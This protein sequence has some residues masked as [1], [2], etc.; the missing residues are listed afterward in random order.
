M[1]LKNLVFFLLVT[2]LIAA[3]EDDNQFEP[4]DYEAVAIVDDEL[5]QEYLE[6]HYYN[7]V[8]DSIK[9]VTDGERPF[10]E[11]VQVMEVEEND[12]N[13]KL[14]YIVREQGVGY[15]PSE[16]DDVLTTYRGELLTGTVFDK[17]ESIQVGN[18][19]FNLTGVIRGWAY[20]FT[21]FRGGTNIS[22]PDMP[23]EFEDYS[24]GFLFIPSGLAYA[25]AAQGQIPPSSPLVFTVALHHAAA[26]DHDDD[27][28]V[29]NAEDVD[30]DGD[31]SNDDTDEDGFANFFDPDDDGDGT[32]TKNED[33]NGDGDPTN[34]DTD[35]DGTPDYLDADS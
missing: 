25:G 33:A 23:I 7:E 11:D 6:T 1:K 24:T 20:G 15:Q 5:L 12:V 18:P 34:D 31:P 30:G 26:A 3:C 22:Q 13:Y 2:L 32:L 14:Y 21:H 27:G 16:Y 29:T 4:Y 28:V 17:R 10:S 35:G 8:L 9:E 19:W